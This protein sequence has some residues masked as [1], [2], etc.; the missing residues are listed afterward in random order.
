MNF[1]FFCH[2]LTWKETKTR[3]TESSDSD[4][5]RLMASAVRESTKKSPKHAINVSEGEESHEWIKRSP[6]QI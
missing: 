3:V 2:Y 4:I 6:T 5:K 1:Y